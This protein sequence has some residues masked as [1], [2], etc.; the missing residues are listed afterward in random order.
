MS[1]QISTSRGHFDSASQTRKCLD[2]VVPTLYA[3]MG[4]DQ[5]FGAKIFYDRAGFL[6]V[7]QRYAVSAGGL[8]RDWREENSRE[9]STNAV[10]FLRFVQEQLFPND[11]SRMLTTLGRQTG[12]AFKELYKD[13]LELSKLLQFAFREDLTLEKIDLP[14]QKSSP[15]YTKIESNRVVLNSGH[16]LHPFLR[17]EAVAETRAYLRRELTDLCKVLRSSNVDRKYAE[18]FAKL[19]SLIIFNDDAGAI[20]FGLHV[21]LISQLTKKVEDEISEVLAVQIAST[22]NPCSIFCISVQG[23]DRVLTQ[24]ARLSVKTSDRGSDRKRLGRRRRSPH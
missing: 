20:S 13:T 15:I 23:L 22:L 14:E 17:S 24:C 4:R 9:L 7:V 18:A 10:Q 8:K 1:E 5:R 21:R 6:D 12:A 16:G 2:K 3:L 11:K 19:P